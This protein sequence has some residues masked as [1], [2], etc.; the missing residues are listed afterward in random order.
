VIFETPLFSGPAIIIL[1]V[2]AKKCKF[3]DQVQSKN[4][5]ADFRPS[6]NF[7]NGLQR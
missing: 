5:S 3:F 4:L 1:F 6:S 2:S 7:L